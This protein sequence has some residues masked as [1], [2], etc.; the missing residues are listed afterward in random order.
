MTEFSSE[1][2]GVS[3]NTGSPD[4]PRA[5]RGAMLRW[6][7][8]L[9]LIFGVLGVYSVLQ[10]RSEHQVLAQRT[11]LMTVPYVSVIHATPIKADRKWFCP[12]R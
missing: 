8:I 10:R 12:E 9:F 7:F 11:E 4:G 2:H 5:G 1:Q 3:Q 6:F